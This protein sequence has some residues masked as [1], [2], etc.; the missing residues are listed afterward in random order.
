M[1]KSLQPPSG[2][3]SD[4]LINLADFLNGIAFS[5]SHWT[6]D[7]LPIIRIEQINNPNA[8]TDKFDGPV[9]PSN[10]IDTGDLIFAWSATLKVVIW[11]RG[12][13]VL[14]Q[15]LFKVVPKKFVYRDFLL[16]VLNFNMDRLSGQ[17]QGSTMKH[18][19]RKELSKFRVIYPISL[20]EQKKIARI[21]QTIDRAIEKTEALIDK[22][23]QIKAGLM[24]DLFTRGI[25]P[26]G[27]LRPPREQAPELYQETP[28]GWIP[29]EWNVD[30]LEN[31][32]ATLPN[33]IRSGPFGSSLLK[34]ELV[35]NGVPFLGIDNIFP[36]KF[37][38]EYRRFVSRKKFAELNQYAVRPK[39][40][41]ITI[42][43]TVGRC[44]VAP[45]DVG[46][47]LSSKHLWTMTIDQ[48]KIYPELVCWQLN[49]ASWVKSWFRR[50]TQGGIM[51][52]IRS[53]TLKA[54][55]LPIP[56]SHEQERINRRYMAINQKIDNETK[57]LRKLKKQKSGLMHDLLTGKVEVNV[58]EASYA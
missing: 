58:N 12:P 37:C 13:A 39:D 44:A 42:M 23:H 26:D 40:V 1:S 56:P 28:I 53:T 32:L 48:E 30:F 49:H 41:I 2:W 7:G 22:Y 3:V 27:Q 10:Y 21:L 16:H 54:L 18:V 8:E 9:A 51:E 4:V 55:Q 35:E 6:K 17:S 52:A 11:D 24:H 14:N 20:S 45:I 31:I 19:T 57:H 29:K 34:S 38:K 33:S 15:H 5:E 36:E 47:A 43:G 50:E 25:G 46:H